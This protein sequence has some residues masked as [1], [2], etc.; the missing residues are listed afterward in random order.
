MLTGEQ[1][2]L[3]RLYL[4][5]RTK[6]GIDLDEFLERYGC[7]LLQ[8]KGDLLRAMEREGLITIADNHLCPTRAGLLLSDSLPLL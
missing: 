5:L 1:L 7:D 6:R 8:E 4:G 3:E 2:R